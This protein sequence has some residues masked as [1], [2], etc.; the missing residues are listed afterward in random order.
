MIGDSLCRNV[1][2]WCVK[3]YIYIYILNVSIF[4]DEEYICENEV[5]VRL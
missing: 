1:F 3:E 2:R 4:F 5:D